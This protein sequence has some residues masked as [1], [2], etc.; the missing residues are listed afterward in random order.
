MTGADPRESALG[1]I[2]A[3]RAFWRDLVGEVGVDRLDEPGPMGAWTFKD[4]AS[5]LLGWR[6]RMIARIEAAAAARPEP[7]PPWPAELTGDEAINAWIR[8][9]DLDRPAHDVLADIDESYARLAT[10]IGS[11]PIDLLLDRGAFPWMEGESLGEAELFGHLHH[12]HEASIRAWLAH[13]G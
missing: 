11:L 5:H 6:N 2:E 1:R 9:Q 13:R 7:S 3:E 12:E 4:L 8:E 10:A